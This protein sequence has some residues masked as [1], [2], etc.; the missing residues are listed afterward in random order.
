VATDITE[1]KRAEAFLNSILQNLPIAV[2]I[3]AAKDLRYLLWNK[4][5]AKLLGDNCAGL[6]GKNDR[7]F[8]PQEQADQ[9]ANQ[10]R[11]TL[12]DGKLMEF[13]EELLTGVNGKRILHTQR[14]R[15]STK[16]DKPLYLLG[17]S[18]EYHLAKAG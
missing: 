6:L 9:F 4:A 3:K 16:M 14:S 11:E 2:F 12:Q 10:D 8:F 15:S 17:I 18:E 1:R 5:G 7:D 13:E